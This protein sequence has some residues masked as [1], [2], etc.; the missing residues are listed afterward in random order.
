[1]VATKTE[2]FTDKQNTIATLVKALGHPVCNNADEVCPLVIGAEARFP[3]KYD[4][5]KAFDGIIY[6]SKNMTNEV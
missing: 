1:M 4:A 5:P 2:H 3:I 6:K